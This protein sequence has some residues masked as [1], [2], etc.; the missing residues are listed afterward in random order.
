MSKKKL[1][2]TPFEYEIKKTD[3]KF[4]DSPHGTVYELFL[5]SKGD[6]SYVGT[7]R[8]FWRSQGIRVVID[9]L[10]KPIFSARYTAAEYACY[11]HL[12]LKLRNE[13]QV[14]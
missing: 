8:T 14:D 12:A 3:K 10:E 2:D 11:K 7:L 1:P 6:V 5:Y 9:N 4:E 13:S